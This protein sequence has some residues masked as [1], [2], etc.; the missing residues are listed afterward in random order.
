MGCCTL[1]GCAALSAMGALHTYYVLQLSVQ[2]GV[3]RLLCVHVE[4]Q[5]GVAHFFCVQLGVQWG[6][7]TLGMHAAGCATGFAHL[8]CV[9]LSVQ[10]GGAHVAVCG[11]W[12][13]GGVAQ[14]VCVHLSVFV[15]MGVQSRGVACLLLHMWLCVPLGVQGWGCM[16][17]SAHGRAMG[18]VCTRGCLHEVVALSCV[19]VPMGVQRRVCTL[20]AV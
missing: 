14:L 20:C 8:L 6:R 12:C 9:Q 19:C 3:A 11:C 17:V 1:G 10:C 16:S 15:S 5:W 18:V 4:M 7:C 2:W 13:K